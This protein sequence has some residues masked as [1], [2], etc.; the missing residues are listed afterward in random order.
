M[1]SLSVATASMTNPT[2]GIAHNDLYRIVTLPSNAVYRI[3]G[4]VASSMSR[5]AFCAPIDGLPATN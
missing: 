5:G 4:R 2:G 3:L 1:R